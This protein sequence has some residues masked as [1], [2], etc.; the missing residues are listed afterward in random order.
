MVVINKID[1]PA[2]R[3]NWVIDQLFDLFI[4]LWATDEQ[5]DFPVIYASAKQGYAVK[6]LDDEK[7]DL[8][9]LFDEILSFVPV[10]K[11][12]SDKPFR[13]QIANLW[14]DDYLGRLW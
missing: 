14:Y 10:A 13:M 9:P 11:D 7:K 12:Y 6:N 5:A 1:K 8:T 3:P 2:A 4:L